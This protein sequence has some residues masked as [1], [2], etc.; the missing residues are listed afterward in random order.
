MD[1]E[2]DGVKRKATKQMWYHVQYV[3]LCECVGVQMPVVIVW[4]RTGR[5][6]HVYKYT[7]FTT[8]STQYLNSR[9]KGMW[10]VEADVGSTVLQA[11]QVHQ[12]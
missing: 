11:L 3:E 10:Y 2:R 9:L 6:Q 8:H 7:K 4:A 12:P 5:P 1:E